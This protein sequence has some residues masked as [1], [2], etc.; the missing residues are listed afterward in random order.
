[1]AVNL[2]KFEKKILDALLINHFSSVTG[3]R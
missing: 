2:Y 1:V 3:G